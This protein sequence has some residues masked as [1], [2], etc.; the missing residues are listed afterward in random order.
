MLSV[1]NTTFNSLLIVS[2]TLAAYAATSVES[3][4]DYSKLQNGFVHGMKSN[5][6][7][8]WYR[9]VSTGHPNAFIEGPLDGVN[10]DDHENIYET[11]IGQ[12]ADVNK[13]HDFCKKYYSLRL[14]GSSR[15][16]ATILNYLGT[17]QP[18]NILAAVLESPFD[19]VQNV[20]DYVLGKSKQI[21][22]T[23]WVALK[24]SQWL[25][26]KYNPAGL[27]P[28]DVIHTIPKHIPILLICSKE[29]EIVSAQSTIN[30]YIKLVQAGHA[31]T[32]L[33]I[34]DHGKHA[35][36]MIGKD[37]HILRDVIHAFYR[38]YG[39]PYNPTF[40][41]QGRERFMQCQPSLS[42]LAKIDLTPKSKNTFASL[43]SI[44]G[45]G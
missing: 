22:G 43:R 37:G 29:D 17:Y 35:N 33:L 5:K 32:Y 31:E 7:A 16:S 10:F 36:I 38:H 19:T 9:H 6:N 30:L 12:T 20:I 26:P 42:D 28:K 34:V 18:L 2:I 14:I 21:P 11:C 15:G 13:L 39:L 1:C 4:I 27:Q 40:A 45:R 25:F 3:Y 23:P 44:S 8:G 24:F 41:E